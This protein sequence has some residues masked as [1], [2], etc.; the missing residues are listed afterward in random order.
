ML[1]SLPDD[2]ERRPLSDTTLLASSE[3]P[4][5][6]VVDAGG[7]E[8]N[9]L[10][11][12]A[13][14]AAGLPVV[15]LVNGDEPDAVPGHPCYAY[16]C[17]SVSPT[18]LALILREACERARVK[19]EAREAGTQLEEL[20][21]IGIRLSAERNLDALLELILTKGREITRSDAGSLY[22]VEKTPDGGSCLRFKLAQN[23][24]V[25]VPFSES[26]LPISAE[27][28]AGFVALSGEVLRIDDAYALPPESPF[29]IN[30]EFDARI[31]Y[32][33]TSMLVVA[34]KTPQGEIIGV[35]QFINCK[36]VPG[37][38]FASPEAIERE[39]CHSRS[40]IGTWRPPWPPRLEWPSRERRSSKS[41][42]PHCRSSRPP[43][44]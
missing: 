27:S 14:R 13:A 31:G 11:R 21:A 19:A 35:L 30:A 44:S 25:Q 41:C 1:G 36:R 15:A 16:L 43:S 18:T 40:A 28:V 3:S 7:G 23:D 24:S 5:V 37:Q 2:L 26:T 6:L 20:T 8:A 33:T 38:P 4:G 22:V 10:A 32:R 12:A 42:V 29:H 17:S 39:V 9:V 34:M